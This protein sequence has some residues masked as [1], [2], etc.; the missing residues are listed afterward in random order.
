M[1]KIAK[2]DALCITKTAKKPYPHTRIN[3]PI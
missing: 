1:T 3:I 2:I